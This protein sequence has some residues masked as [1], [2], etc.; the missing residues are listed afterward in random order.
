MPV[1]QTARACVLRS[2]SVCRLTHSLTLSLPSSVFFFAFQCVFVSLSFGIFVNIVVVVVVLVVSSRCSIV[3]VI[4]VPFFFFFS[5]LLLLL[6]NN[7]WKSAYTWH[8]GAIENSVQF[9]TACWSEHKHIKTTKT[10][11]LF[12]TESVW[13]PSRYYNCY[14]C[15]FASLQNSLSLRN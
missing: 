13:L 5:L 3:F 6:F 2:Y 1:D 12:W 11:S 9:I 14:C 8:F 15:C 10:L 4:T 7:R